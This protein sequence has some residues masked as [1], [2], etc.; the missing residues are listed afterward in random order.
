MPVPIVVLLLVLATPGM[1]T[2]RG[3][4]PE[5]SSWST[6]RGDVRRTGLSDQNASMNLGGLQWSYSLKETFSWDDP[7]EYYNG[8][9]G[10]PAVGRD[11]TVYFS[12]S[13]TNRT[14]AVSANGSLLWAFEMGTARSD[15]L[16]PAVSDEG[17]VHIAAGGCL[18]A[19]WPNGTM[20]WRYDVDGKF[21]SNPAIGMDGTIYIGCDDE[22]L[23]AIGSNG[24]QKWTFA[25]NDSV[26]SSPAVSLDGHI[27]FMAKMGTEAQLLSLF[28]NGSVRWAITIPDGYISL[29]PCVRADGSVLVYDRAENLLCFHSNGTLDWTYP[30]V[31]TEP[32]LR[33]RVRPIEVAIGPDGTIYSG[34]LD[35][36]YALTP[37]GALKWQL[38]TN[39]RTHSPV[40]SADGIIFVVVYSTIF[41]VDPQGNEIW[42]SH[43]ISYGPRGNVPDTITIGL[44]GSILFM[45]DYTLVS[46]NGAPPKEP[47]GEE[48]G[49]MIASWAVVV[50]C[51]AIM[52][53]Q[54]PVRKALG[55]QKGK[56][57]A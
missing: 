20:R 10:I 33:A 47:V 37:E 51:V 35:Y 49:S 44:N 54:G 2:V 45:M 24:I 46:V 18:F 39:W 48:D 29:S 5:E 15:D 38:E 56:R 28:P 3:V 40:V 22:C 11:G 42:T 57:I 8:G 16:A 41:A 30:I 9:S 27:T 21:L 19:L 52:L 31:H 26:R 50:G 1:P 17:I 23:H 36:L 13:N 12:F 55:A 53:I 14:N 43:S 6:F 4:G 7:Y 25:T 34:S 32:G